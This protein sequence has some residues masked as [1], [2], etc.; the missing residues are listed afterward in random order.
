MMFPFLGVQENLEKGVRSIQ[1]FPERPT[2]G[3]VGKSSIKKK[4]K[5]S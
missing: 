5:A 4:R 3:G 2:G 1:S